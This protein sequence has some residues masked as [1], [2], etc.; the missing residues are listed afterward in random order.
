MP[1]KASAPANAHASS[2]SGSKSPT[3][4]RVTGTPTPNLQRGQACYSCRQRKLRCDGKKPVCT[5]CLE[6]EREDDCEY[7]G[8]SE[9]PQTEILQDS[10]R[11]VEMKI[12]QLEARR[13]SMSPPG[14]PSS[15]GGSSRSESPTMARSREPSLGAT[16]E[17][18]DAFL[19]SAPELGF[20][21]DPTR[22]RHSALLD[23]PANHAARPAPALMAAVYLW[24]LRLSQSPSKAHKEPAF[25]ARACEL[26]AQGLAGIHPLR[27]VH[28]LQAEILL[29]Q[30]FFAAE[31]FLEGKYHA[32]AATAIAV[33][34]VNGRLESMEESERRAA[35]Y[36]TVVLDQTWA[37]VLEEE[38]GLGAQGWVM[39][40]SPLGLLGQSAILWQRSSSLVRRWG[41]DLRREEA[42]ALSVTLDELVALT[43]DLQARLS[44]RTPFIARS[45][46]YAAEMQLALPLN[47]W[48]R[49]LGA[50]RNILALVADYS[51]E[52]PA[53]GRAPFVN[54]ILGPIW[55]SAV[56]VVV[57]SCATDADGLLV[58]LLRRAVLV[59]GTF[60][61][62][63]VLLTHHI[64]WM[65]ELVAGI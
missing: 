16:I 1:R 31:R 27:V 61:G 19:P 13:G 7:L 43:D 9:R 45:I 57:V 17:L 28:T 58:K 65:Q 41:V 40:D 37:V 18:I 20:F 30:Y 56:Q 4:T 46:A 15:S 52:S 47:D 35:W 32:A 53:D 44:P 6:G 42:Q 49:R 21:L 12:S 48:E 3:H 54:P 59:I 63:C 8:G 39:D 38:R 25:L 51:L 14:T 5:P 24:G 62:T 33:G 55:L 10:I 64:S 11:R 36:T 22:F 29:A 26:A 2:S 50:A 34:L 23:L 60:S